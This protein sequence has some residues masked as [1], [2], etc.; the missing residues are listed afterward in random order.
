MTTVDIQDVT[1]PYDPDANGR[2][3]CHGHAANRAGRCEDLNTAEYPLA[4]PAR[5]LGAASLFITGGTDATVTP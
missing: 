1:G 2:C 4:E 3:A 5:R